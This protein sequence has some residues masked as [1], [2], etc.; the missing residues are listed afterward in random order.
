MMN[1]GMAP[2]QA[3]IYFLGDGDWTPGAI[4][5][6]LD[7][8]L[9]SQ[10]VK[11]AWKVVMGG[12]WQDLDLDRRIGFAL[13]KHYSELAYFLYTHNYSS[14]GGSDLTKANTARGV[15]ET[16]VA[17]MAGKGDALTQFMAELQSGKL[18][19]GQPLKVLPAPSSG[20]GPEREA[21]TPHPEGGGALD[22]N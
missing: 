13:D 4:N 18:K 7:R 2:D 20:S 6:V 16:K 17:G 12:A 8:W 11:R 3:I 22:L 9:G 14:V 1:A 19:L 5:A 15:L 10:A 21:P